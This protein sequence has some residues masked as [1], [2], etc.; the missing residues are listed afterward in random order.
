[1]AYTKPQFNRTFS[2]WLP[3]HS[4]TV[5]P[6]DYVIQA[7]LYLNSR[8]SF[9]V[10]PGTNYFYNP[11]IYIRWDTADT[12]YNPP[13]YV[14]QEWGYTDDNGLTWYFVVRYWEYCHYGFTNSYVQLS[15][16]Q[17]SALRAIPD[18]NR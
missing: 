9:D 8:A 3:G 13:P 4:A 18:P 1:M 14:G 11:P 2:V 12:I 10:V 16:D 15:V 5:D 7:Q 17:C 6:F